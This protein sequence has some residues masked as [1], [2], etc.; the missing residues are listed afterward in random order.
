MQSK[1]IN[2]EAGFN[3]QE[4]KWKDIAC[5]SFPIKFTWIAICL[6]SH[7]KPKKT[8]WN[9]EKKSSEKY[10]QLPFQLISSMSI[11]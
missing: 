1:G 5:Y 7:F 11:E 10:T 2:W 9:G 6:C 8:C 3:E 4:T